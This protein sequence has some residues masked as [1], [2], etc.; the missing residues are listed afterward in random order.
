[1]KLSETLRLLLLLRDGHGHWQK[2][3]FG[4]FFW[5][6]ENR[7]IFWVMTFIVG[8]TSLANRQAKAGTG[9]PVHLTPSTLSSANYLTVFESDLHS[10]KGA[11]N[12]YETRSYDL[13]VDNFSIWNVKRMW[14]KYGI[15]ADKILVELHL[16]KNLG[17]LICICI[18]MYVLIYLHF[19]IG[20]FIL[21]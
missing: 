17:I 1:M 15:P 3:I 9:M 11:H 7:Q 14:K 12:S 16:L 20:Q 19:V 10:M 2:G 18:N 6:W 13:V 21:G 4:H 8:I 5:T